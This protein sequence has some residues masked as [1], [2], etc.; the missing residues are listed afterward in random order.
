MTGPVGTSPS[1]AAPGALVEAATWPAPRVVEVDG[2]RV[3]LSGGVTRRAG[4]ALP[5]RD[6]ADLPGAVDRVE[7][8]YA[9]DG[10]PA[11]F[12]VGDPGNPAGLAA[13]LERR[14]YRRVAVTAVL[15]RALADVPDGARPGG[16]RVE[17]EP[18]DPWL[19][20]W[21]GGKGGAR[22]VSREIVAAAPARYLTATDDAGEDVGV[23]RVAF[24]EGWAA[25]SCLQ[26]VPRAR[27]RG[28]GRALTLAAL[29]VAVAAGADRAFLQVEQ[30]NEAAAQLYGG[31]G[32]AEAH[33]YAYLVRPAGPD[34]P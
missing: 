32:F 13:E 10:A 31:L 11:T 19:D 29:D 28:L 14:G 21:L 33:R 9:Q 17:A 15:V 27:R 22:D 18:A 26:V 23:V 1:T 7:R 2:W 3:G 25:L 12:R 5:L 16:L 4:S 20:V 34:G 8:W 30:D 6:V 24:A